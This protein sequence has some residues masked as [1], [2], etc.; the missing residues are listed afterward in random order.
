[1]L[2]S[3]RTVIAAVILTAVSSAA[4]AQPYPNRPIRLYVG[5]PPG[6]ATD[7]IART[8]GTPLGQRLGQ[9][10]VVDNRPGSLTATSPPKLAANA[11][12]GWAHAAAGLRQFVRDFNPHLYSR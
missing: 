1:M 7:V 12:A 6:G 2:R 5:Y 3:I 10:V 4:L 11:Q 8:I 9:N